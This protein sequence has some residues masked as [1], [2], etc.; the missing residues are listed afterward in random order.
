M[1]MHSILF[2]KR[3]AISSVMTLIVIMSLPWTVTACNGQRQTPNI[4]GAKNMNFRFEDY[5]K[6]EDAQKKLLE[7]YPIGSDY[8][9]LANHLKSID[10]MSC[11]RVEKAS[12]LECEYLIPTSEFSAISWLIIIL[13]KE[14]KISKIETHRNFSNI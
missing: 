4:S 2:D 12:S 3:F 1:N 9:A 14:G 6:S 11:G 10:R 7:L 8:K 13:E 5:E